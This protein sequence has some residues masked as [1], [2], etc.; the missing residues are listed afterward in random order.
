MDLIVW[1]KKKETNDAIDDHPLRSGHNPLLLGMTA[2]T[3]YAAFDLVFIHAAAAERR[4]GFQPSD[5]FF[6]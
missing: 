5:I 3:N 1:V 4:T 6:G 2:D